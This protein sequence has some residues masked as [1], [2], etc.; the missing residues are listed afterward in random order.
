MTLKHT[1][2][3]AASAVL[4]SPPSL[5]VPPGTSPGPGAHYATDA[6]PGF[7]REAPL[8]ERKKTPR[9]FSWINGPKKSDAASQYAFALECVS[10]QSYSAACKACDALVRE[11]P[12][13]AQAPLAQEK[14]ADLLLESENDFEGAFREYKYLLDYYSSQCNFDAIAYRLYEVA[15]LMR[16]HGKRLMWVRFD[17]N[18]AVRHA[19]EAVVLRAPGAVY[20]PEAMLTIAELRES[21]AEFEE[22]V[23][24]YES[25]RMLYAHSPAAR[26]SIPREA[27]CRMSVLRRHNYN[28]SLNQDTIDFLRLAL[29]SGLDE[30]ARIELE[31]FLSEATRNIEDEAYRAAKFYDSR[32]RTRQSAISAYEQFLKIHPL[33]EHAEKAR[34]RIEELKKESK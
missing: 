29:R 20:A 2:I 9:W 12:A 21:D 16:K 14:L 18:V 7:D 6:Y 27:R 26:T 4:L 34:A 25:I 17:N 23:R 31:G 11:W 32:T 28:R 5:A 10:N 13:S 8:P 3:L 33:S 1:I 22:A 15:K 24:V 30:N 19:F